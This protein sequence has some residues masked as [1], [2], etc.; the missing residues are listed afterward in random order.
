MDL[1]FRPYQLTDPDI[2]HLRAVTGKALP[3][4]ADVLSGR[5]KFRECVH[6]GRVIGHCIG[7]AAT[8]EILG[9]SVDHA[10][11]RQ[12]IARKLLSQVVDLLRADGAGRIWLAA[13]SDSTLP[14][15]RFYRA[16]GWQPSGEQLA[17]GDEILELRS[18]RAANE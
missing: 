7:N 14:A 13:P 11:R 9:L 1:E 10:Y 8:G 5:V 3:F 6:D 16:L 15:Y 17:G 18:P 12:G 2:R 4:A